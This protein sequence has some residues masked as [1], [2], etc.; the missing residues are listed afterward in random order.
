[1]AEYRSGTYRPVQSRKVG[2]PQKQ[3]NGQNGRSVLVRTYRQLHGLALP[4]TLVRTRSRRLY[5]ILRIQR[6]RR[7]LSHVETRYCRGAASARNDL[8]P[9]RRNFRYRKQSR[10]FRAKSYRISTV[11][12]KRRLRIHV[13][14]K[15]VR[16]GNGT[17]SRRSGLHGLPRLR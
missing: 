4:R 7:R 15:L 5:R 6:R 11:V 14:R 13:Q 17:N 10:I 1:M 2:E 3:Q 8:R 12:R 9:Y 16:N